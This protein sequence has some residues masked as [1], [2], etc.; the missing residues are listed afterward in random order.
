MA[1]IVQQADIIIAAAGQA[2]LIKGDWLKPGAV[3]ID[4]GVPRLGESRL[5][6]AAAQGAGCCHAHRPG[7]W[8]LLMRMPPS[9]PFQTRLCRGR[10]RCGWRLASTPLQ[11]GTNPVDDPSK[12]A[13]Y[14]LVGDAAFDECKAVAGGITP[15]PGGVGPMT[16][17]MLLKNTLTSAERAFSSGS[18]SASQ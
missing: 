12:A 1:E 15:V 14:R 18:G 17:A 2:E 8:R 9:Q 6:Q 3:L 5:H 16:I 4:V 10:C 11:V 7:S 13:G